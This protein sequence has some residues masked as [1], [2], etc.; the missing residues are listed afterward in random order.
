MVEKV[1]RVHVDGDAVGAGGVEVE[2][3]RAR[4]LPRFLRK[5]NVAGFEATEVGLKDVRGTLSMARL[6]GRPDSGTAQFF[7]NV[8]NNTSLDRPQRDGAAYAVFGKVTEGM[9]VV[10][11]IRKVRTHTVGGHANV[12]VEPIVIQ[13]ARRA[14]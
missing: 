1:I 13:T 14:P 6:G 7:I 8:V 11:A 3:D 9:D 4:L 10:D 2:T 5:I 12:P